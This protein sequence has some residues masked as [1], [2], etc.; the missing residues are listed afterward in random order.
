MKTN[1]IINL[2]VLLVS[3]NVYAQTYTYKCGDNETAMSPV[4]DAK[5]S[6]D[7]KTSLYNYKYKIKNKS[8]ALVPIHQFSLNPVTNVIDI[9]TNKNWDFNFIENIKLVGGA[10]SEGTYANVNFKDPIPKMPLGNDYDIAPG[11]SIEGFEFKSPHPPGPIKISFSGTPLKGS[12]IV[13]STGKSVPNFR[14]VIP[15]DELQKLFDEGIINC[16]G[17][18]SSHFDVDNP[19]DCDL[20]DVTTGPIP[21]TRAT[22]KL[23]MRK[24]NEKKWRGS[25]TAE[26]PNIQ[27]LPIDT[28][29]I[30]V[31]LFGDQNLDVTKI[32][33]A[34]ITFGQG[35]AK[36]LKT[37]IIN[38]FRDKD[39]EAD[40]DDIKEH[41]KK[42]NVRHLLME[43][44]LDHV[45]IRC[46]AERALFLNG[47]IGTK[48][49]FGAVK[50]KHGSCLDKKNNA[51][52][53]RK[54]RNSDAKEKKEFEEREREEKKRRQ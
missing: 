18:Y 45:D 7:K 47:K 20:I 12:D 43:F 52:E 3:I 26:E 14:V 50:I 28:G 10:K 38:D 31:M 8:D 44:N 21:P 37:V 46:D 33:L 41:I 22:A 23:R 34:S 40:D 48:D 17:Y 2:I 27:I 13:D 11:Q 6:Y 15:K 42:N 24:I 49:L 36:P 5:V 9:N 30:E 39:G 25:P 53:V 16:P 19:R 35:K 32:D 51:K 29:K 1:I 4:V 54:K